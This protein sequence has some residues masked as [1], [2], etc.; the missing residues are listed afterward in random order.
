MK[1][2]EE[3]LQ[4]IADFDHPFV[5]GV[6]GSLYDATSAFA[7]EVYH[8]ETTDIEIMADGWEALSGF[9]GQYS[10]HGP[11][12]HSSELLSGRIAKHILATPGLYVVVAVE[13]MPENDEDHPAPAGWAVLRRTV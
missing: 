12:M 10:Y 9:T 13:V 7:P 4:K 5:V 1:A 2:T 11:V 8:S 6:D 3:N